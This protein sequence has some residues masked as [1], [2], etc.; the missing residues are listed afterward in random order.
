[1]P[2]RLARMV[3]PSAP[4]SLQ[5]PEPGPG[6]HRLLAGVGNLLGPQ[7]VRPGRKWNRSLWGGLT[8]GEIK[9]DN[10]ASGAPRTTG[11]AANAPGSSP[12]AI[13]RPSRGRGASSKR[14]KSYC[15]V[16]YAMLTR[17]FVTDWSGR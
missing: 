2:R 3:R 9:Y 14:E 1:M 5:L 6:V 11:A 17:Q 8:K 12:V 7:S 4:L 10:A 13:S 15:S 16:L